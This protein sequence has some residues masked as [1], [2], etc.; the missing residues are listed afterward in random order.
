LRVLLIEDE[1]RIS[2]LVARALERAGFVIDAFG[3]CADAR[4][5]LSLIHYD[6]AIL[7]LGL[8]TGTGSRC[9]RPYDRAVTRFR[10]SF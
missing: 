10:S 8:P 2:E 7:D 4:E 1:A 9:S 6:A 3:T 5:A